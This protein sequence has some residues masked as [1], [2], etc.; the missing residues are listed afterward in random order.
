VIAGIDRYQD[1]RKPI[2]FTALSLVGLTSPVTADDSLRHETCLLGQETATLFFELLHSE[3]GSAQ[4]ILEDMDT[5]IARR[6]FYWAE[7]YVEGNATLEQ[8][9]KD[10]LQVC[11]RTGASS[12]PAPRLNIDTRTS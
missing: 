9:S 3:P 7:S 12:I 10:Y 11:L 5:R 8:L 1:M 2:V 6:A 4:R